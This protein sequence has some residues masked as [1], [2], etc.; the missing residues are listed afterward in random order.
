MKK[1]K[2]TTK[3]KSELELAQNAFADFGTKYIKNWTEQE[4]KQF[5]TQPVVIPIGVH[6]FFVGSFRVTGVHA[7]CWTVGKIDGHHIHDFTSKSAAIIYCISE[8]RQKYEAAQTLLD[9]DIKLGRLDLD[10]AQYEYTL[11]KTQD[12]V[13]SAAV[14]N[15]CIDAKIQRRSLLN[16]L[17]KTLNSAKYLNFGKQPL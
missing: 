16:I 2:S 11:S 3:R 4:L 12:L 13:K 14:L 7:A 1:A 15:R 5:R 10:I 9:L 6:G 8:V 17:K